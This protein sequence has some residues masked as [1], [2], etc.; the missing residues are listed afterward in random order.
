MCKI[1]NPFSNDF[2]ERF[3]T[4]TEMKLDCKKVADKMLEIMKDYEV[5]C[6]EFIKEHESKNK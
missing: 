3:E 2:V 4:A 1:D 5:K 6:D